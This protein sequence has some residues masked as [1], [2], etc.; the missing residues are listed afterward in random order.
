MVGFGAMLERSP[1]AQPSWTQRGTLLLLR[2]PEKGGRR[3]QPF[4]DKGWTESEFSSCPPASVQAILVFDWI[5]PCDSLSRISV[6]SFP[7]LEAFADIY[8]IAHLKELYEGIFVIYCSRANSN[9]RH[10][11][12]ARGQDSIAHSSF[13]DF[14]LGTAFLSRDPGFCLLAFGMARWLADP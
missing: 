11:T 8:I 7:N 10:L 3:E 12:T 14:E 6:G 5:M 2:S 9:T 13:E 4:D 1:P